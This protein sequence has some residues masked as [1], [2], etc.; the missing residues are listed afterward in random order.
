LTGK[1]NEPREIL[2]NAALDV[3]REAG[4]ELR[5]R[6]WPVELFVDYIAERQTYAVS[7]RFELPHIPVP[8]EADG[9]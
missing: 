4:G 8:I 2:K 5:R 9:A 7:L 6:G 3:M 1:P